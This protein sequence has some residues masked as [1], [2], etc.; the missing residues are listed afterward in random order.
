MEQCGPIRPTRNLSWFL[1][2]PNGLDMGK[3]FFKNNLSIS[4]KWWDVIS[5][6]WRQEKAQK[7]PLEMRMANWKF[8]FG[9]WIDFGFW[10]ESWILE[11]FFFL[12]YVACGCGDLLLIVSNQLIYIYFL[13]SHEF[14]SGQTQPCK[15]IPH[16][17]VSQLPLFNQSEKG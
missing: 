9:V 10:T 1:R 8:G 5:N 3:F 12:C 13:C 14:P 11:L 17:S 16:D 4:V 2:N 6:N 7:R 15:W